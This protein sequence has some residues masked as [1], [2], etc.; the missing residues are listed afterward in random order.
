MAKI[1]VILSR[2]VL[3]ANDALAA[4]NRRRFREM[5][6]AVLNL[7]GSPGSG[8]TTLL[9]ATLRRLVEAG[10]KPAVIEGDLETTRDAQRVA[11]LGV[12]VCQINT[13]G[14]CHLD[15]AQVRD[16]AAALRLDGV[17]LLF[18]ENVGNLVCPTDFDLGETAKVIV[19]SVPEGDD[20]PT[21]YA[22]CFDAASAVVISKLDLLPH[23]D[24]SLAAARR[25]LDA[26]RPG[27]AIF[28]LAARTGEG[29]ESWLGWLRGLRGPSA[30]AR[31]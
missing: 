18:I 5:G 24:F 20:K 27:V 1:E 4:E 11:A 9:E 13:R 3:E 16:A 29:M 7:I 17:R 21:K 23:T 19:L 6:L 26:I 12:P 25:D 2:N 30:A 10:E 31:G 14:G 22:G 15:A 8:K 28:P